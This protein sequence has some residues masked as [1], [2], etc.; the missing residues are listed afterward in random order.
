MPFPLCEDCGAQTRD[1]ES[2]RCIEC[3]RSRWKS[4]SREDWFWV[5]T[6][7][8][9]PV[10]RPELN[11]CWE[12]IGR[13]KSTGYGYMRA[14]GRSIGTHRFSWGLHRGP[15]PDGLHVLHRCDN[16]AC[17]NP[18]HLFLGTNADNMH[19]KFVKAKQAR[20]EGH[21][22]AKLT[23]AAVREIRRRAAAGE[24]LTA[25]GRSLGVGQ[26]TVSYVVKG[27]TWK[28]VA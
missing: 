7:K 17:V 18:A 1:R 20:G 25:I 11:H 2:R 12:W 5:N 6:N 27:R 28:H 9:G 23:D 13:V 4:M 19:D 3:A 8:D 10:V 21:G 16:R 22:N 24:G 14:Y 15:I 26:T